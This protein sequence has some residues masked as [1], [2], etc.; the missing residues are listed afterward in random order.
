MN[1]KNLKEQYEKLG[2][3]IKKI[4]ELEKNKKWIPKEDEKY[5]YLDIIRNV[6][7]RKNQNDLMDIRI[8]K[9][10]KIF[11]TDQEA[12]KYIDYLNA[13][14]EYIYE[15]NNEELTHASINKYQIHYNI[16]SKNLQISLQIFNIYIY[17]LIF[18]TEEKAQEFINKYEKEILKYEFNIEVN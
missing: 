13:R 11:K 7:W 1:L 14:D 6:Y 2:N 3:E 9:S 10:N 4:E 16:I 18:K 15:F 8:I 17:G 12:R 5:Y